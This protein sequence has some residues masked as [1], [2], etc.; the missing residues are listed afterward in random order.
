MTRTHIHHS[1]HIEFKFN[2]FYFITNK[3]GQLRFC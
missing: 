3:S 2:P 1:I